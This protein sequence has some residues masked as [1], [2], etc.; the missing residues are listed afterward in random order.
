MDFCVQIILVMANTDSV[1]IIVSLILF[2]TT[3][4]FWF[5]YATF[6]S[7]QRVLENDFE[8]WTHE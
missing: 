6:F 2:V 7:S 3:I 8:E 4:A 1:C 5:R